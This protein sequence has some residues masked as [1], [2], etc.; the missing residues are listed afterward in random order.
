MRGTLKTLSGF[1]IK[2]PRH[3]AGRQHHRLFCVLDNG[4]PE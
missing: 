4:S 3:R 2:D 1:A